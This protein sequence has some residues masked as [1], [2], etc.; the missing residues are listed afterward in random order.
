[1]RSRQT[2]SSLYQQANQLKLSLQRELGSLETTGVSD[3]AILEQVRR[4]VQEYE[5]LIGNLGQ[6]AET[7]TKKVLWRSRHRQLVKEMWS[8]N[9]TLNQLSF[10][11]QASQYQQDHET[12]MG[13]GLSTVVIQNYQEENESLR[14]S[15]Q[16]LDSYLD[17]GHAVLSDLKKQRVK[18]KGI[19]KQLV[20]MLGSLGVSKSLLRLAERQNTIDRYTVY[21][22]IAIVLLVF[23]VTYFFDTSQARFNLI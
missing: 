20:D 11:Q 6:L 18:L 17:Q 13:E 5:N 23:Y 1:M 14:R 21:A 3:N 22:G 16:N 8:F 19:G 15:D 10:R 4:Q 2:V 9:K 7:S 12:L